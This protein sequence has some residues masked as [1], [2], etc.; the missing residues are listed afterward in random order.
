MRE[1]QP[2]PWHWKASHP[3]RKAREPWDPNAAFERAL[4]APLPMP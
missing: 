3:D 1:L 4:V 2:G